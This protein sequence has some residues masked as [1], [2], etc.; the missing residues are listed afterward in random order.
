MSTTVQ[1]ERWSDEWATLA[2]WVE[3]FA[4]EEEEMQEFYRANPHPWLSWTP[5]QERDFLRE[6]QRLER[7]IAGRSAPT[8][9]MLEN[10]YMQARER[11]VARVVAEQEK[12]WRALCRRAYNRG[13]P[14]ALASVRR[15]Y[16]EPPPPFDFERETGFA[17]WPTWTA[18]DA[19]WLE[20][21]S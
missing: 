6:R 7:L 3:E 10:P 1:P 9:R 17:A 8:R 20:A 16:R 14:E 21:R 4:H 11:A 5:E 2:E 12:Q 18:E 15:Q 19:A 13:D